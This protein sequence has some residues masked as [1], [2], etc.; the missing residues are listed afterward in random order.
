MKIEPL[1][2]WRYFYRKWSFWL[3]GM[4][5]VISAA[6]LF[7]P[8][9]E[10]AL[11]ANYYL[12]LKSALAVIGFIASQIKQPAIQVPPNPSVPPALDESK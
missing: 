10:D 1:E 8:N 6:Q 5:P 4:I 11:P 9:I 3:I 12:I 2:N 7:I